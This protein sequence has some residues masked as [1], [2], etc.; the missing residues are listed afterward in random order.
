MTVRSARPTSDHPRPPDDRP[1]AIERAFDR[2]FFL[3]YN[4]L[5]SAVAVIVVVANR[6]DPA[7]V[8]LGSVMLVMSAALWLMLGIERFG[9]RTRMLLNSP[10]RISWMVMIG[11]SCFGLGVGS[12]LVVS[13][14]PDGWSG[15]DVPP[16]TGPRADTG[17]FWEQRLFHAMTTGD[18]PLFARA[19]GA[20][21][22]LASRPPICAAAVDAAD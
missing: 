12:G 1:P 9:R 2:R 19:C 7:A 18:R 22:A 8:A 10:I 17:G 13:G 6:A 20:L 16:V 5:V 3:V 14:T 11:V 21:A 15:R 4:G